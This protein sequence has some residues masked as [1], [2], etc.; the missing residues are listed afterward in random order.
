VD[1][2]KR[3][4]VKSGADLR[5]MRLL[6]SAAE[7]DHNGGRQNAERDSFRKPERRVA[8]R[9]FAALFVFKKTD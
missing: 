9:A 7:S 4:I 5:A 6:F 1:K 3:N 2:G 8:A